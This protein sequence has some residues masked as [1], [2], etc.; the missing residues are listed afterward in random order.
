MPS[1]LMLPRHHCAA[2]ETGA[3]GRWVCA[4]Q[5]NAYPDRCGVS[6]PGELL[7]Q[8]LR[9][10]TGFKLDLAINSNG[11]PSKGNILFTTR[12]A[13]AALGREGYALTAETGTEVI[14]ASDQAGMFYGRQTLLQLLPPQVFATNVTKGVDWVVAGVSIE[15]S[16]ASTGAV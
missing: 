12:D 6:G 3:A 15:A 4:W 9:Q 5:E 16:R 7:A 8:R 11:Q 13:N 10:A 2:G 14:R 1:Q